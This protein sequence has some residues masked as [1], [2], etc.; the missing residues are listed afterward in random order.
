MAVC[1]KCSPCTE[2]LRR[3]VLIMLTCSFVGFFVGLQAAVSDPNGRRVID[4]QGE[5]ITGYMPS[6]E[7]LVFARKGVTLC[8]GTVQLPE[9]K[10]APVCVY[11]CGRLRLG[12]HSLYSAC[13]AP[14]CLA[15]LLVE[16]STCARCACNHPGGHTEPNGLLEREHVRSCLCV[17]E[18]R[19]CAVVCHVSVPYAGMWV[20]IRAEQVSFNDLTLVGQAPPECRGL[21][22]VYDADFTVER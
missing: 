15:S 2:P 21:V 1:P 8:N 7:N 13:S 10:W 22:N 4:L 9:G 19:V 20:E 16:S 12:T 17:P 3:Q 14:A 11:V 18:S 5:F 6:G